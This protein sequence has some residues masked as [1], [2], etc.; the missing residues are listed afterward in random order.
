MPSEMKSV[1]HEISALQQLKHPNIVCLLEVN[2]T[3]FA[4]DLVFEYCDMTLRDVI[5]HPA[6]SALMSSRVTCHFA[7][8]LFKALAYVHER[9]W[10]HRDLKPVN[11]LVNF[12][13]HFNTELGA[14][15]GAEPR[16]TSC[17]VKL[18]DFGLARQLP[19]D[20]IITLTRDLYTLWYRSPEILLGTVRYGYASDVWATGCICV[21]MSEFEPAFAN[22]SEIGM[23]FDIFKALGSPSAKEWPE[24]AWLTRYREGLFPNFQGGLGSKWG[25]RIGPQYNALLQGVLRVTHNRR[26]S[27]ETSYNACT[28]LQMASGISH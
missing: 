20:K 18:A 21:E 1:Q 4:I 14:A 2:K 9:R 12:G 27:A 13:D 10:L 6:K 11:I 23:L 26:W 7:L 25:L 5:K 15:S 19:Q 24:I 17:V 28:K 8:V 3:S 16:L 22:S